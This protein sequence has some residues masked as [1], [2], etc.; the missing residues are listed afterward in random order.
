MFLDSPILSTEQQEN[1]RERSTGVLDD[2]RS[3]LSCPPFEP[4]QQAGK[5]S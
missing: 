4:I 1:A 3:E 2:S 5:C